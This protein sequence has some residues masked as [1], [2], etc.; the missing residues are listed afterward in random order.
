M[1]AEGLCDRISFEGETEREE[2]VFQSTKRCVEN[3]PTLKLG[4][5]MRDD[6]RFT[7]RLTLLGSITLARFARFR[8]KLFL[9]RDETFSTEH[10]Y[11]NG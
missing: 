7:G 11:T 4:T 1:S 6:E 5:V 9:K 10:F 2:I 8:L 3:N